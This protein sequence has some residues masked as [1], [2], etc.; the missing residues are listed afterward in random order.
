[1]I[2]KEDFSKTLY[3]LQLGLLSNICPGNRDPANS[4]SLILG[5]PPGFVSSQHQVLSECLVSSLCSVLQGLLSDLS[6][7]PCSHKQ[8]TPGN[9]VLRFCLVAKDLKCSESPGLGWFCGQIS[10]CC[11]FHRRLPN[12]P[13]LLSQNP[14]SRG[15]ET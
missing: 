15:S 3:S 12:I 4:K 11:Q 14:Q 1:M 8:P 10:Q 2:Q 7:E 5:Q 6:N 9:S 13:D